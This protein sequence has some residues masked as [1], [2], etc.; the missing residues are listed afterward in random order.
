VKMWLNALTTFDLGKC[1]CSS[2]TVVVDSS[3]SLWD[4]SAAL[5]VI[6]AGVDHDLSFAESVSETCCSR[7]VMPAICADVRDRSIG[8]RCRR[9]LRIG[10]TASDGH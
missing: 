3:S 9:Y 1:R 2:S 8:R 6:V 7:T 5:G 10:S 4:E